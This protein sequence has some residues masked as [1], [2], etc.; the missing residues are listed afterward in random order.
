MKILEFL[1][2]LKKIIS[3][4]MYPQD[5]VAEEKFQK[6]SILSSMYFWEILFYALVA[7]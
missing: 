7:N 5:I 4:L 3:T 6:A 1:T 2:S